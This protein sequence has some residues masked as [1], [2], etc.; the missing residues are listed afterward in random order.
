M[1]DL[2]SILRVNLRDYPKENEV[3]GFTILGMA[4]SVPD[5]VINTDQDIEHVERQVVNIIKTVRKF[6]D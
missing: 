3:N 5:F 1:R 2:L 6:N 4:D